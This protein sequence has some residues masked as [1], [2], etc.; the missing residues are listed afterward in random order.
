[1]AKSARRTELSPKEREDLLRALKAR[2]EKNAGRHQGLEWA[3]VHARLEANTAKLWSLNEMERTGGE[4]DVVGHDTTTGE[5]IFYDCSAESPNG[6]RSL[7]YDQRS[8]AVT[9]RN[10]SQRTAPLTWQRRM[11]I[12]ILGEEQYRAL[13]TVRPLRYEDIEL[14][15][16]ASRDQTAR[17]RHLLRSPVRPRVRVSQRCRVLRTAARAFAAR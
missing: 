9:G 14:G 10:T 1:M 11:G 4:P 13:Q 7:C 2:F 6:R 15:E 17:R 3:T 16:D 8:T 5:C 12:E